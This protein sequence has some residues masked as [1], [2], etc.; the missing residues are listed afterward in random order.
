MEL[1]MKDAQS[2]LTVSKLPSGVISMKRLSIK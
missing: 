2:A 1:V